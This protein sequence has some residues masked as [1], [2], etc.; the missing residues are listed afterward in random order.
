MPTCSVKGC[1]SKHGPGNIHFFRFPLNDKSHLDKWIA[2]VKRPDWKPNKDSRI[3]SLHFKDNDIIQGMGYQ[4]RYLRKNAIPK[5]CS[6]IIA[7]KEQ[8]DITLLMSKKTYGTT[9]MS[10][11]ISS[12]E[13]R[14]SNDRIK[15]DHTYAKIIA[16]VLINDGP[17]IFDIRSLNESVQSAIPHLNKT[18]KCTQTDSENIIVPVS[19]SSTNF[20]FEKK[21]DFVNA[22][23]TIKKLSENIKNI[24]RKNKT[25]QQKLR[26]QNKRIISMKEILQRL[27]YK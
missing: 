17:N 27:Q 19:Y 16:N 15:W 3:C 6:L 4:R 11:S 26:R 12:S 13:I 2:A 22:L 14:I 10:R 7:G 1:K 5:N 18:H 24:K 9:N 23:K 21:L 20:N 8:N 25:L